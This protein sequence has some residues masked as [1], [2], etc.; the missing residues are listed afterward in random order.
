MEN[1]VIWYILGGSGFLGL[2]FWLVKFLITKS[3][4]DKEKIDTEQTADIKKIKEQQDN[5]IDLVLQKLEDHKKTFTEY[6]LND[7]R[8]ENKQNI[9]ILEL[10][11]T[12]EST[13]NSVKELN[14]AIFNL[15]ESILKLREE[16]VRTKELEFQIR[17]NDEDIREL[18][19]FVNDFFKHKMS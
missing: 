5:K 4:N 18:K 12:A 2:V 10:S 16:Y 19:A 8:S 9:Q 14:K 15:N 6:L 7:E 1:Q 11:K 17:Q 3:V 13:N